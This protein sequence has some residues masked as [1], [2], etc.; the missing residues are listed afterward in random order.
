LNHLELPE[1][2]KG[3]LIPLLENIPKQNRAKFL[4][5]V[6]AV[7]VSTT[8]SGPIPPPDIFKE[9]NEILPGSA[10]R[11]LAMAEQQSSHRREMEKKVIS[12]QMR[13]TTRGQWLGF[14]LAVI[15]IGGGLF[16]AYIDKTTVASILLGATII[17]L[18]SVFVIGKK[19][20]QKQKD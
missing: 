13:Q 1:D 7:S 8:F 11:I 18:V 4:Q 19:A 15:C 10:E 16:L 5:I 12:S 2:V 3:E 20:A 14:V 9:Y 17:S 6:Q